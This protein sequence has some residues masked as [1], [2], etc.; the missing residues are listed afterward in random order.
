MIDKIPNEI[1]GANMI[2]YLILESSHIKTHKTSHWV[3]GQLIKEVYSLAICNY[4]NDN[5]F[6]LYRCNQNWET[7]ADTYHDTIEGAKNQAEFEFTNTIDCWLN[8]M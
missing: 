8:K 7:L 1:D 4:T 6:Y 2:C 5:G 3:G